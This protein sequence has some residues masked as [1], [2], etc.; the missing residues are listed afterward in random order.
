MRRKLAK[1]FERAVKDPQNLVWIDLEMTGLDPEHDRILEIA[2]VVTDKDLKI[3]AEGPVL[4]IHQPDKIL[5][6]MD[7]WNTVQHGDSGLITRV[8]ESTNNEAEAQAQTLLFLNRYL[9][10]GKSPMCG[11]TICQDRRFLA[12]SMPRLER[13][14]HYRNLDVSSLKELAA[15]W[16]PGYRIRVRS[17]ARALC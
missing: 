13:F 12:R 11:N 5:A 3:L 6:A 1:G 14:F 15:R 17:S 8:R 4:A 7:E 9:E 2:T 16:A 10:P